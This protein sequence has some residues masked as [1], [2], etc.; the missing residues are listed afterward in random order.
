MAKSK[1]GIV[2][3]VL[4]RFVQGSPVAVLSRLALQH[5][6]SDAWVEQVFAAHAERQYTREVL[7][8]TVV[9]LMTLTAVGLRP[10]LHAAAKACPDLPVSIQALYAKVRR[11]ELPVLEA[12][13]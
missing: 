7:F 1:S 3:V 13:V 5:A 9:E 2:D 11:T 10:S 6:V 12:L 8:S 4:D